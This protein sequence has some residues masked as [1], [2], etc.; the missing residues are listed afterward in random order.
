MATVALSKDNFEE[1]VTSNGIV[2]VDFWAGWCGPCRTFA[3][4]FE[5][6]AERH[7]DIVFAK[8]DTENE[9]ELAA[10][11]GIMSIPNPHGLP[12]PGPDLFPAR[13]ATRFCTGGADHQDPGT[14]HG[15]CPP[16]D[17]GAGS[18]SFLT[19]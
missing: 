5:S 3:P 6:A 8:V 12:G 9:Y 14:G 2:L 4:V 10:Q 18:C 7:G 11:F 1:T 15:R 19:R 13:S 17:P 16:P